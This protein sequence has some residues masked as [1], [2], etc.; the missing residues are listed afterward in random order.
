MIYAIY[1]AAGMLAVLALL[2]LGVVLGWRGRGHWQERARQAMDKE[3]DER[4][5]QEAAEA[6]RAFDGLLHYNMATAYGLDDPLHD[7]QEEGD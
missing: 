5:R 7:L 3:A 6:Q 1:G 2:G 4:E